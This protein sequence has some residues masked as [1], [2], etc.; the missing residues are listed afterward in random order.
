MEQAFTDIYAKNK[1]GNGSGSGSKMTV[2]N[3]KYIELLQGIM[4]TYDITSICDIGCG[5][6]QFSRYI[7]WGDRDYLGLDCVESVVSDNKRDYASEK[8][9]FDKRVVGPDYIPEGYDL[10][11][12]KDVIQHWS[13]EDIL[14]YLPQILER[15]KYVFL[16]NGYKFMRDKTKNDL[17]VRDIRNQ[18]RYHPVDIEKYPLNSLKIVCHSKT[19]RR[20]KQMLLLSHTNA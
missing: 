17:K 4:T 6:W 5:D 11:I 1:W 14:H 19:E 13:D 15:N 7:D 3:R 9:S 20:A 8:V 2:D 18:Y 16:T 10:V 12:L